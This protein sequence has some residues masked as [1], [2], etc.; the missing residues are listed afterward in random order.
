MVVLLGLLGCAVS[1]VSGALLSSLTVTDWLAVPPRLV[2]LTV[3]S[4]LGT[5]GAWLL[6]LVRVLVVV[7][8][9]VSVTTGVFVSGITV[10]S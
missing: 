10:G 4:S 6:V 2:A 1:V 8:T 5:T 3:C 9:V 7:N